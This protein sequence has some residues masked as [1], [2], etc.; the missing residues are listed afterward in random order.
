[1]KRELYLD[2]KLHTENFLAAFVGAI[3][4]IVLI[5]LKP[6]FGFD[7]TWRSLVIPNSIVF[8]GGLSIF[9]CSILRFILLEKTQPMCLR[10]KRGLI[11]GEADFLD[12]STDCVYTALREASPAALA[13]L[14]SLRPGTWL[15]T[16]ASLAFMYCP[17]CRT[18]GELTA[19]VPARKYETHGQILVGESAQMLAY[20]CDIQK[21]IRECNNN[22]RIGA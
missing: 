6:L 2:T 10:C 12:E 11:E 1:M 15:N 17:A 8:W 7:I 20:L 3:S 5:I 4:G 18:V 14:L 13:P 9:I 21:Q 22:R 16:G 19:S